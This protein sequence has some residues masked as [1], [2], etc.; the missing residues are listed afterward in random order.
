MTDDDD[1]AH[2]DAPDPKR[3]VKKRESAAL[4][5]PAAP[6]GLPTVVERMRAYGR[7][8]YYD[9]RKAEIESHTGMTDA[10]SGNL[11]ARRAL[12]REIMESEQWDEERERKRIRGA[13]ALE[14]IEHEEELAEREHQRAVDRKRRER[15][16]RQLDAPPQKPARATRE[17]R[18][19]EEISQI[20]E[21]GAY[22]KFVAIAME[23]RDILI[24]K[25]GGIENLTDEDW[26]RIELAF[27]HA[28][29]SQE[30]K[31]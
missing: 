6:P 24:E 30:S 2:D 27:E 13:H 8:R 22:G 29:R 14:D 31:G 9:S 3:G 7:R 21:R 26:E 5:L 12:Q 18:V 11:S 15:E 25:R 20:M 28:R 10:L 23:F 17:E 19:R 1:D 16:L 4:T